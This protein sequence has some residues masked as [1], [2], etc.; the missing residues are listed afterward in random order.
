MTVEQLDKKRVLISLKAEEI[1]DYAISIDELNLNSRQTKE[2][3]TKILKLAL[4][5]VGVN[6][7]KK[8]VL[9][10]AMP[11]SRGMLILV[12]ADF[13]EKA[14]KTYRIKKPNM[15]A[16]C[17]FSGAEALLGCAAKLKKEKI[18]LAANSLWK[19]QNGFYVIF[20]HGGISP[21]VAALLSEYSLCRSVGLV[22][23]ARIKEMGMLISKGD[24]MEKIADAMGKDT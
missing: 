20:E 15:Q 21:R 11:H 13:S 1:S 2:A 14:V 4:R 22:G 3:L 8:T 7:A 19:Y 18:R 10:E 6:A 5:Q 12:T 16:C 24:A 17:R 23:L 9:V